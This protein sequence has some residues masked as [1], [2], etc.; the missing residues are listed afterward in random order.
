LYY[1]N[2][3][4]VTTTV[5]GTEQTML[6]YLEHALNMAYLSSHVNLKMARLEV[7]NHTGA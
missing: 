7:R 1:D 5:V 2:W 3:T 4:D 6:R